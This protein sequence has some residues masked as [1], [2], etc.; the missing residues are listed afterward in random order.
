M[1][2]IVF[3]VARR[4]D[5]GHRDEVWAY[6]KARWER[7]FPDWPIYEGHHEEGLFNRSAAVNGAATDAGDWDVAIVLDSD[8][9]LSKSWL[10]KAVKETIKTDK[11][12]WPHTRIRNMGEDDAKRVLKTNRDFGDEI[13][14]REIDLLVE[15]TNPISWS[16][17]IVIPRSVYDALGGFDERFQGWGF[18][19]MAFQ[20]AVCGL[21]GWNRL[22]GEIVHFWHPKSED[23]IV[24]GQGRWTATPEYR[25]N[26][27]LGRRYMIALRRDHSIHD[28]PEPPATEEVRQRDLANLRRDDEVWEKVPRSPGE[29]DW[30]NWWPTL[31][32][33]V[34]GARLYRATGG[35]N[36]SVAVIVRSGGTLEVADER[37][38]YLERSLSSLEAS[39]TG[40]VEQ[41]VVY[42][43][44]P[45]EVVPRVR[46]IAERHGFYVAGSGHHGYVGSTQ[47]LWKYIVGR[48]KSDFVFL[49]EDDFLYLEPV[50]LVPMMG[51]LAKS[52]SLRQIALL[53]EAAY[54]KE[55]E[56][57]DHI[58]GWDRSSFTQ[59]GNVL[60]HRNFWTMNPSLIRRSLVTRY[61]WP[62][63]NSS[64][65][66]FGD[67]VLKDPDAAV[68]FWGTGE[69]WITHIGET[70]AGGP[71]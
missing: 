64:E 49:A 15:R 33:L 37:L 65:R 36:Q 23:R 55:K 13:D 45:D 20:S 2:K 57:G 53:R 9:M 61:P 19:D 59:R 7:L 3:L 39:L 60:E 63:G 29:P 51:V 8:V 42:S 68:G 66:L 56:P 62:A 10:Q 67:L 22:Q 5:K 41:R 48:V 70:R 31:E 26:A 25:Y 16:C 1:T 34:E 38:G 47:R 30:M 6:C 46:E 12:T 21:F 17:C 40:P 4:E 14:Q 27:R 44:W 54:P 24:S 69:P 32:E 52:P 58:L 50:D 35:L 43:D 18:E 71:Y 11:V 28:R